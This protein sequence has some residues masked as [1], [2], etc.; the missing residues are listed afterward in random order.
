MDFLDNFSLK[1]ENGSNEL[2]KFQQNTHF[3]PSIPAIKT[4]SH[5]CRLSK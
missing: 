1:N 5:S 3:F 4:T 2:S